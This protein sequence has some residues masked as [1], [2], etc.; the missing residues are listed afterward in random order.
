MAIT[1]LQAESLNLADDFTFTGTVAGA[2]ENNVPAFEAYANV[3]SI[4]NTTVTKLNIGGVIYDTNSCYDNITNYRFTPTVA[5]KYFIYLQAF[6]EGTNFNQLFNSVISIYKNGSPTTNPSLS[7]VSNNGTYA[8][9]VPIN[10]NTTIDMNGST[11]YIEAYGYIQ[12][13]AGTPTVQKAKFG[14]FLLTT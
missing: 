7:Y 12:V 5:G 4:S 3:Q 9:T 8:S 2:G 13:S 10:Y 11:D 1:K 14:G 6:F